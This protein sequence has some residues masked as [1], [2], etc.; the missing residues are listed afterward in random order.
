MVQ[1]K[2]LVLHKTKFGDNGLIVKIFTEKY[3]TLSF[4]VKNSFSKKSKFPNALFTPLTFLEIHFQYKNNAQL[5]YFKEVTTYYNYHTIPFDVAKSSIFIFYNELIYKLLFDA[6]SDEVL[7][8]FIEEKLIALDKIDK[9]RP[10]IHL[11]FMFELS[12]IL[13]FAPEKDIPY[14]SFVLSNEAMSYLQQI[15]TYDHYSSQIILPIKSVRM[16]VLRWFIAYYQF[17]NEHIKTIESVEVL[18]S[19]LN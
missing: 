17:Y 6:N 9:L 14:P 8:N 2:G 10:D 12:K 4:F 7:F 3:G 1:T 11:L 13:G 19:I 15:V 18:T 16:E 5:F